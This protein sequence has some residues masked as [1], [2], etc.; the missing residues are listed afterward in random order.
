MQQK[1]ELV[2]ALREEKYVHVAEQYPNITI[3]RGRGVLTGGRGLSVDGRSYSTGKILIATGSQPWAPPIPGLKEAGYLD[4]TDALSLSE[5]PDSMIVVG[6]GAIG[7]EFAQLFARFGVRVT[8]FECQP[9]LAAPEEPE[10]ARAI[11]QYLGEEKIR[12]CASAVLPKVERIDGHYVVHAL[13]DGKDEVC[14]ATQLLIATGRRPNTAEL[15]L[16]AAGVK[17]GSK[18]EIVVNEQ[19]Q[20]TNP[21]VYAAGDCVG[22]P[23]FVYVAAYAG[24]VAA[25]NAL[26]GTGRVYDLSALPRVTFTDP[27]M[28]SVGLTEKQ[29]HAQGHKMRTAVLE[30]TN[31]PRALAARDTRGVIK[32]I[33]EEDTG[34]L[35]GAHVLATD[36]GEVIQEATLAIRFGLTI[37][38][39]AE[40]FHPYLT[41]VEGLNVVAYLLLG[42][43]EYAGEARKFLASIG[44]AQAPALWEAELANVLW[45][46]TRHRIL[47]IEEATARLTLADSLGIHTV[48]N[49]TLWRGAVVRAHQSGI[50]VYDTLFVELAVREQLPLA[51]FDAAVLKAFPGIA[52]RPAVLMAR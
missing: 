4:S 50:A 23:M 16:D 21:D 7:L 48:P 39:I 11:T 31:V 22:D 1:D 32:L 41:M 43:E 51:T 42:T 47:T 49:R 10:I 34:R 12:A 28:A 26:S 45:M 29:A 18:G 15:G 17:T 37:Q 6:A 3:L 36:G 46:A 44:E 20:T 33:A 13:L 8:V 30:L 19:L 35:L 5:L 9:H 14:R 25:E 40:T 24:G 38:D 27:Q 2:R 52:A